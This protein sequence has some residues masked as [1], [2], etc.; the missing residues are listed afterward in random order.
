MARTKTVRPSVELGAQVNEADEQPGMTP[1]VS[2]GGV[3]GS[4]VG[5][6]SGVGGAQ[7]EIITGMGADSA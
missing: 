2:V 1:S 6:G 4:G 7:P 5:S 3:P